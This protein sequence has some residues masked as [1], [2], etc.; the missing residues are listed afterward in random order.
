M[1][2]PKTGI[3]LAV[4]KLRLALHSAR[5]V[6]RCK[7]G[8]H[9]PTAEISVA[10]QSL[11]GICLCFRLT[12]TFVMAGKRKRLGQCL[13]PS[14]L[15]ATSPKIGEDGRR[16]LGRMVRAGEGEWLDIFYTPPSLRD[17][18]PRGGGSD[19]LGGWCGDMGKGILGSGAGEAGRCGWYGY[20]YELT[21]DLWTGDAGCV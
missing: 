6:F 7:F 11:N 18:S 5:T 17:T 13:Y 1:A 2:T 12:E 4:L 9:L 3:A 16:Y 15:T 10:Q 14:G 8:S 19:A 20:E 21:Y